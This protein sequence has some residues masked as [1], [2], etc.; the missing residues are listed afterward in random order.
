MDWRA[1]SC[2]GDCALALEQRCRQDR[3]VRYVQPSHIEQS[4]IT[5]NNSLVDLLHCQQLTQK[6]LTAAL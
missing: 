2:I 6:H 4:M 1:N 5:I 3:Q